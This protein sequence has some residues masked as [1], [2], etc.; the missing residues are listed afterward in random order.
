VTY[1]K[2]EAAN[3]SFSVRQILDLGLTAARQ[4]NWLEV[5]N[6]LKLLPQG[7]TKLFLLRPKDRQ[8][9][10]EL[11]L[12]MLMEADFQHKW[13]ITKLLPL[14][15]DGIIAPLCTLAKDEKVEEEVR[16]FICKVLGKFPQQT[17]I[18]TMVELIQQTTSSEL[19]AIAEK[20]LVEIGDRA[21]D[22]LVDLLEY[23]EHRLLT[24]RAL[25][26]IRT[27]KTII[28]LLEVCKAKEPELRTIA[29]EALSSFHDDRIPAVLIAALQD[30][31]S[32]VRREAAIAL[33]LRANLCRELDLVT[34]LQPLLYDLNPEVCRQTAIALGR[35]KQPEAVAALFEL[36]QVNTTPLELKLD[37]IKALGWS[38]N[39]AAIICLK[40]TLNNCSEFI[41]REIITILGRTKTPELKP[42]AAKVLID[43]W[44]HN[45]QCAPAVKQILATSLG[46]LH[47]HSARPILEQIAHSD[48]RKVKL[49]AVAALKKLD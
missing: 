46:Q 47:D 5:S 40:Q 30:K 8:T 26:Y 48:D 37:L 11:A 39:T 36:L 42:Q 21:V 10:F 25:S 41:V 19:V 4:Q 24:V 31:V 14:F 43:F 23:P 16:W 38:E 33:G 13:E 44:H 17:V 29:I 6:Q 12:R 2:S 18:L 3:R 49:H 45:R 27:S 32:S 9:A 7:K 34:Y 1:I 15:G 22:A 28:P 20:T 35:M